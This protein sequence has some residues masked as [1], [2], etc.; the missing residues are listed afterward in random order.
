M[1]KNQAKE[2]NWAYNIHN[3]IFMIKSDGLVTSDEAQA[4][5]QTC[6]RDILD[7]MPSSQQ[8]LTELAW[9]AVSADSTTITG[10]QLPSLYSH[11]LDAYTFQN[12]E[13]NVGHVREAMSRHC[14]ELTFGTKWSLVKHLCSGISICPFPVFFRTTKN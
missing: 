6:Q 8:T 1:A 12:I 3:L 2:D 5:M 10:V 14:A 13:A 11:M 4:L 7:L 9:D